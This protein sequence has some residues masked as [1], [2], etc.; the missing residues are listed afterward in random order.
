MKYS[1]VETVQGKETGEVIITL[2]AASGNP[3]VPNIIYLS[4]PARDF[5]NYKVGDYKTARF[6]YRIVT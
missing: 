6:S 1:R 2:W 5:I 4:Y 3:T